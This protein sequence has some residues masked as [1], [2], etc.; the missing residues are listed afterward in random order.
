MDFGVDS[1]QHMN[2]S[3]SNS[4]NMVPICKGFEFFTTSMKGSTLLL[5]ENRQS[6]K[7]LCPTHLSNKK[8]F[9]V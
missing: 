4:E 6:G 2:G 8:G 3:K 9:E 5:L 1:Q 7:F